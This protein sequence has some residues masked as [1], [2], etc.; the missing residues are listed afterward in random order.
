VQRF[1]TW[2]GQGRAWVIFSI[3][4]VSGTLS[5]M[6][7][8]VG[9]DV[10][11]VI[12]VQNGLFLAA[13]LGVIVVIVGRLDP[14]DRQPLLISIL[15]LFVGFAVGIV[16]PALML[17]ALGAGFGWL[18]V[19]QVILRR[20][21]RREYQQAIRYLRNNDY[22]EAIH[23]ISCL[24]KAEPE[25]SHHYRF[26]AD[27]YRLQGKYNKAIKDYEQIIKLEP[28]SS[29]GHNGLSEIA[30]QENDLE[31]ALEHARRAYDLE[32]EQWSMSYNLAMIEDRLGMASDAVAHLQETLAAGV[33]DS[34]HRLLIHLWLGRA[35]FRLGDRGQAEEQLSLIRR[36]NRGLKEWQTVLESEQ[37]QT[38][39]QILREDVALA[40]QIFD[41]AGVEVFEPSAV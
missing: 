29:I 33:S 15:P 11:W 5:L 34:R 10:A 3:I 28:E 16:I 24:I 22:A 12:P 25:D 13:L 7:Q 26:R 6:L 37:A 21:V 14:I 9:T 31:N 4:G 41:G 30:L 8:A 39:R 38:I 40:Q 18:I 1:I 23:I 17:W 27:L 36:Q 35:F 32:P 19:S 20:N 2:L